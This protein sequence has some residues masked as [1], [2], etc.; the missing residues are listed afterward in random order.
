[1]FY[2]WRHAPLSPALERP[3]NGF[4]LRQPWLE[5]RAHESRCHHDCTSMGHDRISSLVK[6]DQM[7]TGGGYFHLLHGSKKPDN[8]LCM[9]GNYR[10][11]MKRFQ[12]RVYEDL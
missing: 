10:Y 2:N 5:R 6:R 4:A 9:Y 3:K 11:D 7:G 1:M 12:V 8:E